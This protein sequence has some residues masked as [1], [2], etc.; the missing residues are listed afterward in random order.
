MKAYQI[1]KNMW[2]IAHQFNKKLYL[3]TFGLILIVA[4][5]AL[6]ST[7][8]PFFLKKIIDGATSHTPIFFTDY[9]LL[10]DVVSVSIFR[11]GRTD[12][13]IYIK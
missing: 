6:A 12:W 1:Y 4:L 5:T 9:C 3:Y 11:M 13:I 10:C 7:S 8:L 2:Q